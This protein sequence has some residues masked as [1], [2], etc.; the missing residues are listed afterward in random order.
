MEVEDF[1]PSEQWVA[2]ASMIVLPI[3]TNGQ[4]QKWTNDL[5]GLRRESQILAKKVLDRLPGFLQTR[6]FEASQKVNCHWVWMSFSTLVARIATL[7][8]LANQQS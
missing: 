6:V 1:I 5:D 4:V 7:T 8:V 3:T 2:E